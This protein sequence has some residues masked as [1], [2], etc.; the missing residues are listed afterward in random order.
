MTRPEYLRIRP[1]SRSGSPRPAATSGNC[2]SAWKKK[3]WLVYPGA[4]HKSELLGQIA[5]SQ[6]LFVAPSCVCPW[7][8]LFIEHIVVVDLDRRVLVVNG[9]CHFDLTRL[10]RTLSEWFRPANRYW[11][12]LDAEPKDPC[13]TTNAVAP[14]ALEDEA[15]LAARYLALCPRFEAFPAPK[16]RAGHRLVQSMNQAFHIVSRMYDC[17]FTQARDTCGDERLFVP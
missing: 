10:P 4:P 9:V 6:D 3:V 5:G 1:N 12:G 8:D 2:D 16:T 15:A 7:N 11:L 17:V 13:I 14:P